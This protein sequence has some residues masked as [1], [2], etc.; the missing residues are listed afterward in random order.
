MTACI[1]NVV[2]AFKILF[3]ILTFP[4]IEDYASAGVEKRDEFSE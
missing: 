3:L 4:D 1:C 2:Q